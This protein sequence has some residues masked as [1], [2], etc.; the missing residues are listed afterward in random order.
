MDKRLSVMKGISAKW[1]ERM[2]DKLQNSPQ[3]IVNGFKEDGIVDA[4]ETAT[5]PNDENENP[6]QNINSDTDRHA[7]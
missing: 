4:I 5:V 1:L 6:F 7:L 2:T 3:L